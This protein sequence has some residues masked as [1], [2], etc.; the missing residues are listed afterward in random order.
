MF[1][2]GWWTPVVALAWSNRPYLLDLLAQFTPH[3]VVLIAGAA[4]AMLLIGARRLGI[5]AGV[6]C[7]LLLVLC[8]GA[9]YG[10]PASIAPEPDEPV[11]RLRVVTYNAKW[12]KP[13]P[14]DTIGDW[15][16]EQDADLVC[17]FDPPWRLVRQEPWLQEMYPYRIQPQPG[18]WWS[19]V[20][21]S[22]H[23]I[24]PVRMAENTQE[25]QHSF[26]GLRSVIVML[27]DGTRLAFS[28]TRPRSPRTKEDWRRSII[29]VERDAKIVRDYLEEHD[30]PMVLAADMNSTPTG[31]LHRAFVAV[32]G[33]RTWGAPFGRGTWPAQAPPLFSLPIDRVWTTPDVRIT[34]IRIGPRLSSDHRPVVVELEIPARAQRDEDDSESP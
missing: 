10:G 29:S 3:S 25:T 18:L 16:R 28:G 21:L 33:L 32:S 12:V 8:L 5:E 26:I 11:H 2:I 7:L 34:D 30:I 1:R 9:H 4:A 22:R 19:I 27:E 15:L 14:D 6:A 31:R 23:P 20:L 17:L 24:E 13:L